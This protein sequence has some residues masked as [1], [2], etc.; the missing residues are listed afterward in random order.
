MVKVKEVDSVDLQPLGRAERTYLVSSLK[1]HKSAARLLLSKKADAA[2]FA[3]AKGTSHSQTTISDGL[4]S[5][6]MHPNSNHIVGRLLS[7]RRIVYG[8]YPQ[9]LMIY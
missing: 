2:G 9:N 8:N 7:L 5:D 4:V 3:P 6:L 1:R